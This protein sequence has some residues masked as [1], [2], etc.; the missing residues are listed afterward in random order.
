MRNARIGKRG[1]LCDRNTFKRLHGADPVIPGFLQ[2]LC[3]YLPEL[4]LCQCF[5]GVSDSGGT[6]GGILME[7]RMEGRKEQAV[8]M[9]IPDIAVPL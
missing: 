6:H 9:G 8:D 5:M 1:V 3:R 7:K 2:P 4:L